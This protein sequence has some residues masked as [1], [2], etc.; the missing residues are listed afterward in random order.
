MLTGFPM[1]APADSWTEQL[2]RGGLELAILLAVAPGTRYG[3]EIIRH[4]QEATDLVVGEGTIYPIL[5]RLTR[6][7]LLQAEWQASGLIRASTTASPM[8]GRGG[9]G[10][11]SRT[12]GC[13]PARL[14][15]SYRRQHRKAA[16]EPL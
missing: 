5:G 7:G 11:W 1:T 4:L 6:D 16:N 13:S 12:G 14:T 15:G 2:R 3:L 9:F 10:S 8:P